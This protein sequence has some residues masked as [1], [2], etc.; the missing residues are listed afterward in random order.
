MPDGV[1]VNLTSLRNLGSSV[2]Q[3]IQPFSLQ[4]GRVLSVADGVST[5]VPGLGDAM[6]RFAGTWEHEMELVSQEVLLL[7]T[8]LVT[9]AEYYERLDDAIAGGLRH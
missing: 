4:C 1:S 6:L 2:G 7:G 3:A 9:I 5:G 8:A